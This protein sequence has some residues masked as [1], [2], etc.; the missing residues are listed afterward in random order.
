MAPACGPPARR[1]EAVT[2]S[3]KGADAMLRAEEPRFASRSPLPQRL[4][5]PR[6]ENRG[7]WARSGHEKARAE[8]AGRER[9]RER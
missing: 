3:K 8:S 6:S 2:L 4:N 7:A 5:A 1:R 9:K